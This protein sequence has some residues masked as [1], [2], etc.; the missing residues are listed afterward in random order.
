MDYVPDIAIGLCFPV[1]KPSHVPTELL[2]Y[3]QSE[4]R[5]ALG[6]KYTLDF[7]DNT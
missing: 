6:T 1:G 2:K 4:L 3:E 7:T 5:Y